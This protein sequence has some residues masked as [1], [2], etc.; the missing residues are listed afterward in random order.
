P[1]RNI[2]ILFLSNHPPTGGLRLAHSV[3][4]CRRRPRKLAIVSVGTRVR[5]SHELHHPWEGGGIAASGK[6]HPRP[7]LVA[8]HAI[9]AA[10][11]PRGQGKPQPLRRR[12]LR[13]LAQ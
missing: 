1:S 4:N 11:S 2:L 5:L 12:G 3:H 10:I 8:N 7:G 6:T 13:S 9:S